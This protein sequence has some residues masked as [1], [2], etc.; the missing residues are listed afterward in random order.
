[1]ISLRYMYTY[2]AAENTMETNSF[3]F[4]NQ[5]IGKSIIK[6]DRDGNMAETASFDEKGLLQTKWFY[7]DYE[8]DSHG[9]WIKKVGQAEYSSQGQPRQSRTVFYRRITYY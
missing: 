7:S 6:Y 2:N 9:N 1:M 3:D 5:P 8:F 4:R